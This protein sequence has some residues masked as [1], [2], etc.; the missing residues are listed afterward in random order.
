MDAELA[1]FQASVFGRV[2][3]V[4][5]R[6]YVAQFARELEL[7]GYVRNLADSSVE[8]R[9]E[10]EKRSLERLLVL[11]KTGSPGARVIKVDTDWSEYTGRYSGFNIL[12]Q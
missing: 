10:G 8:V 2:Q 12:N 1:S 7:G 6:A 11:L 4:F 9:A 3:G 5:F